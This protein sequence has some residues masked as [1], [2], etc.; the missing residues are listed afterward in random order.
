MS[1]LF[2]VSGVTAVISALLVVVQTNAMRA[3]ISLIVL[4]LSIASIFFTL[5]GPFAAALQ[6][7][8]YAGAIIVLFVFVVMMLNLGSEAERR[9]RDWLG[10][11]LWI[12]PVFLAAILL[13][14]F[15]VTLASHETSRGA[16]VITPKAV[17]ISLFTDYLIGVELASILLLAALIAAYRYGLIPG[18]LEV[19]DE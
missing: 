1:V 5:G 15:I 6:I 18:R 13:I 12:L 2:Y 17:G 19:G 9:E 16:L 14:Q 10:S 7:I 11:V 8:I 3:L 4:L